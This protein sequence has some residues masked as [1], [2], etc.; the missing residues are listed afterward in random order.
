MNC[1]GAKDSII[2]A[3]Y[4]ELP[5]EDAVGLEQHLAACEACLAELDAIRE[6]DGVFA[7]YPI[8]E[9]D[10]NLVA[11]SRMR[12]DEAL[13]AIPQHGFFTRLQANWSVW[14]GNLQSAPAL[15]TL[16]IGAGFLGGNFTHR[17]QVAHEPKNMPPVVVLS[18][19]SG[20]GVSTI[21][22]INQLPND[23]VQV[24]YNRVVP[25]VAEGSLD[26][27]QIR[28][29]LMLGTRAATST[30][31]HADSVALLANEC[32]VG[33]ECQFDPDG[34][35][36]RNALLVSLRSDKSPSVRLKVLEGLQPYVSQDERVRDAVAQALL[37]DSSSAVRSKAISMLEP[38]QSDS[39]VRQVLRTVSTSDDNPYIRTV[40]T[41]A[42]R[43]SAS[44]Q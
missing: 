40:S 34:N 7:H 20:G 4:G 2:L 22:A 33:H 3:A 27:P 9:P 23:I 30:V 24:S 38:V 31:V 41:E 12:L 1:E 43:G 35:G 5:D 11:Q 10:P 6:M 32:R 19:P 29:L 18:N 36:M 25:E 15:A 39:S 44:I 8:T 37:T 14:L 26:D 13:D 17:Y 21:S 42:L 16:L 28:Q